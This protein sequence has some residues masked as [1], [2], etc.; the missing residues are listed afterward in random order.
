MSKA[1]TRRQILLG[2]TAL[3]TCALAA[4]AGI[5]AASKRHP[6][7]IY[8][9]SDDL[10]YGD[11]SC[12]GATRVATPNIDRLA[13]QG[14][15]MTNG[16]APSA[17][18]TPSRY[19]LLTG[20]YAWRQDGAHILP[21]DA[22]ALIRPGKFTLPTM[23]QGAGYKT[24]V[25]G[26]WHLGLGD[27]TI[28]W[29]KPIAP[30]P[31]EIGFDYAYYIPATIDRVPCV[32]IDDR[33]VVGL[34][35]AD[36]IRVDYRN[37]VGNEPTGKENPDKL[38]MKPNDGHD[39]TIIDGVSRI[40]WMSGGETARWR[41]ENMA[42]HL[43]GKAIAFIE[44]HRETPFFL[45]F[46]TNE[47]HVPRLPALRFRGRSPMGPRGDSILELDWIVGEVMAA[48]DRLGIADD[49]MIVFSS[50]N[51]PVLND[52]YDDDAVAKAGG[53]KPAG[54]LRSG[55]YSVYEGGTRVPM[56]VRWK[57][58]VPAGSVSA[59]L[60]DHVDMLASFAALVDQP[61][62]A[63]AGLDS[64]DML[65]AMLGRRKA[66]RT[67]VIEDTSTSVA[68]K[69]T[70]TKTSGNILALVE[71]QWKMIEASGPSSSFHD[72]DVG[73]APAAQLFDLTSDAGERVDLA[74][75]YPDRV[76]AMG[77]KLSAYRSAGRTRSV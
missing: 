67:Y 11:V 32:F 45:Y 46:A 31:R 1:V 19:A 47:I 64:L 37:K 57:G 8:I 66:G 25:V 6:N 22:P 38:T 56:I 65:S 75:R 27:G 23:L 13:A 39:G 42:D 73:S 53:H 43:T 70:L 33:T 55:K 48:V 28:D 21:G 40:G 20:E 17:T 69:S 41:D 52:G 51:G 54:P 4:G 15:R 72:N 7:I 24:G 59:A 61:L 26:K 12:Y 74:G 76:A 18:C 71:G 34:D 77:A 2:A 14:L 9:Y 68:E 36:P 10:G 29:N 44:Q 49:T 3:T 35:A 50:D 5:A 58:H 62:P 30:G 63:S 60:V 16:H